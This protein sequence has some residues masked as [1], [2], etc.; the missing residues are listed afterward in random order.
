MVNATKTLSIISLKDG[1]SFVDTIEF[2]VNSENASV[3]AVGNGCVFKA[4]AEGVYE[5]TAK[6]S[7][8]AVATITVT[9]ING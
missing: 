2:T 1:Q 6:S 3:Q 5:V 9:V 7:K 4:T 8:G